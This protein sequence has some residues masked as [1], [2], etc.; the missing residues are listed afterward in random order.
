M[1]Y[2][3]QGRTTARLALVGAVA[4]LLWLSSAGA[5]GAATAPDPLGEALR[6]ATD[7]A[8]SAVTQLLDGSGGPAL[9]T[10]P[11][12]VP[13]PP[14]LPGAPAVPALPAAPGQPG[15]GSGTASQADQG[16]SADV[17]APAGDDR[18]AVDAAVAEFLGVCA[19]V[20]QDV[21]PVRAT[22][23]VLDRDVIAELVDAGV[24][25]QPLVVPCPEGA[26]TPAPPAS[27]QAPDASG[28]RARPAAAA[29]PRSGL[30][31]S[32]AF[33]GTAVA[34]TVWLAGGMIA[35]GIAFLRK[36]HLL[37]VVR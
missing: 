7:P 5:A 20:P 32:L 29:D 17:R 3:S 1:T 36:A 10:T 37:A 4:G 27:P 21:V 26:A 11:P 22:I 6:S 9:P 16:A 35:L 12:N 31:G 30:P 34:P 23:V 18:A 14:S 2:R 19:R 13:A 15:Q 28:P 25:L 33:T 8:T 24:P